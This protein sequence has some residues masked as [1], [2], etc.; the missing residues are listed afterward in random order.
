MILIGTDSQAK[1]HFQILIL[2]PSQSKSSSSSVQITGKH[3][4]INFISIILLISYFK[5]LNAILF[6]ILKN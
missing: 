3:I 5:T 6:M 2:L 4:F 1:H